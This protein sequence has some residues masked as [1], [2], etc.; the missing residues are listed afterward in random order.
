[1]QGKDSFK[2][3]I[4]KAGNDREILRSRKIS[5]DE[6]RFGKSV[7][8]C[9]QLINATVL[10]CPSPLENEKPSVYSILANA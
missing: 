2:L 7:K 6:N 4:T 5:C 8:G 1:M 3:G 10:G 9:E